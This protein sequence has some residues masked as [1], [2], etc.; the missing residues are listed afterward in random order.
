VDKLLNLR[1]H[2]PVVP[3]LL[4]HVQPHV[5]QVFFQLL[6]HPNVLLHLLL[7][8]P[9]VL[10]DLLLHVLL[11]KLLPLAHVVLLP[12]LLD[13]FALQSKQGRDELATLWPRIVCLVPIRQQHLQRR[14]GIPVFSTRGIR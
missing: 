12:V 11:Q 8:L 7:H 13:D 3:V 14:C 4:L 9:Y 1:P 5:M 2:A 6:E 10:L